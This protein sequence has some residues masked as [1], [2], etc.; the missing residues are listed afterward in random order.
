MRL[1]PAMVLLI[2]QPHAVGDAVQS[3]WRA[4][5]GVNSLYFSA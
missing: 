2:V 4:D 3:S 1:W 5:C